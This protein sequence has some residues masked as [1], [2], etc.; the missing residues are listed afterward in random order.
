MIPICT[1]Y[2]PTYGPDV[3]VNTPPLPTSYQDAITGP[4]RDYSILDQIHSRGSSQ[5]AGA[6]CL[7]KQ[8]LPKHARPIKGKFVYKW[9]PTSRNIL[10]KPKV[11]FTMKG[12]TQ[13]TTKGQALR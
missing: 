12:F 11:R 8:S 7:E 5:P 1:D 6:W 2:G 10:H 9:K 3:F 13:H 4:Y